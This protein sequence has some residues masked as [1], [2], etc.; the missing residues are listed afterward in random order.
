MLS[1]ILMVIALVVLA[2]M[3]LITINSNERR[4]YKRNDDDDNYKR[5]NDEDS[6]KRR[7]DEDSYQKR[8]DDMDCSRKNQ[9]ED[10]QNNRLIPFSETPFSKTP[11]SEKPFESFANGVEDND[12]NARMI[13]NE[14]PVGN[15]IAVEPTDLTQYSQPLTFPPANM[16]APVNNTGTN[17]IDYATVPTNFVGSKPSGETNEDVNEV[18][19]VDGTDLLAAPLAD[20]FY[21]TNSIANVNRNAT[22]DF[23]GD[24]PISYND[25]YTPFY[26]SAIYGE[27][28]T[29]N[30]LGDHN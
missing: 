27:P 5:R 24:I 2:Y 22:H 20:R 28:L 9:R 30:R 13:I 15:Q 12:N 16:N 1:Q 14:K 18:Y 29:V 8:S 11:F 10:F 6:Y 25:N 3:V 7:D 4:K 19:K 23:R 17:E 21:Y 26:Q